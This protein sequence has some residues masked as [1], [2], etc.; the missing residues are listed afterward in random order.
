[1]SIYEE[2]HCDQMDTFRPGLW[3]QP[4][5]I[6]LLPAELAATAIE[7][8]LCLACE[9]QNAANI[10]LGRRALAAMPV[11]WLSARIHLIAEAKLDLTDE[12]VCRRLIE[13]YALVDKSLANAFA[14]SCC[15]S[16]NIKIVEAGRDYLDDPGGLTSSAR[17]SLDRP[18]P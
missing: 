2:R 18:L 1:M 11:D 3:R 9:S 15:D 13:L 4:E 14:V 6:V 8:L 17:L 16:T 12:W 10:G 5:L 7:Y